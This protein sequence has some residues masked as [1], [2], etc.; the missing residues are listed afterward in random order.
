MPVVE[1]SVVIARPPQE[2]FDFVSKFQNVAVF[3]SSVTASEQVAW[4]RGP[5]KPGPPVRW[6]R[7]GWARPSGWRAD[8]PRRRD[9]P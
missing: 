5:P 2:V 7:L 1:E 9:L 6:P 8:L 4:W 3:D